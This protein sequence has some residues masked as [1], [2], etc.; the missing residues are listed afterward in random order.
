MWISV[1]ENTLEDASLN[2]FVRCIKHELCKR[3]GFTADISSMSLNK[4][5]LS[6]LS[7]VDV[8]SALRADVLFHLVPPGEEDAVQEMYFDMKY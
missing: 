4:I 5:K 8:C 3:Y 6:A 2:F 1:C 7:A